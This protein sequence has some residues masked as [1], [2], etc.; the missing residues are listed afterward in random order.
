MEAVICLTDIL[1]AS[2]IANKILH[3]V[4]RGARADSSASAGAANRRHRF[5]GLLG[6]V[7][8]PVSLPLGYSITIVSEH[9]EGV[10]SDDVRLEKRR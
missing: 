2:G 10:R 3:N 1:V 4:L 8:L 5:H 7:P 6:I 9:G